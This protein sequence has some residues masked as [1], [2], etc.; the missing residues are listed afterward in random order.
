M[1]FWE[2]NDIGYYGNYGI[3]NL[4]ES[5]KSKND[6]LVNEAG[7]NISEKQ[8]NSKLNRSLRC[9]IRS[10]C[11][12]VHKDGLNN[13]IFNHREQNLII[14]LLLNYWSFQLSIDATLLNGLYFI[15]NIGDT[16]Y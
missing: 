3:N 2:K 1:Y 10:C 13:I 15:V 6:K 5:N 4:W 14:C 16:Y 8:T 12:D 11:Q 7:E 9:S